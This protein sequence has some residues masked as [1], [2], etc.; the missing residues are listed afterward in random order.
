MKIFVHTINSI[1]DLLIRLLPLNRKSRNRYAYAFLV[2]SRDISDVHRKYGFMKYLPDPVLHFFTRYHWPV[3]VSNI[4]GLRSRRSGESIAGFVIGIPMTARQMME[5]RSVAL[6]RI[7]QASVLARKKG[8]KIIGLG[9]LT[10]SLSKGG[11]DL[12]EKVEINITTGHAYTAY[13]VTNTL[14]KIAQLMDYEK[15]QITV[16][17]VGA[18]GSVGSTSAQILAREGYKKL[19]LVD[20]EKRAHYFDELTRKILEINPTVSI[21]STHRIGEIK[22][23]DIIITATNAPEAVIK[24]DDLKSG[25]IVIDDAQPSDVSPEVLDRDDVLVLDAGVVYTHGINSN[26]NFGLKGRNDNFC[27]LAE[28]LILASEEW[29]DHFV[30][31]RASLELVDKIVALGKNHKFT[32]AHFQ[33]TRQSILPD[34]LLKIKSIIKENR[35]NV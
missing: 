19:I 35:K 2:H 24:S 10:S 17:I 11:L 14:L 3:T 33:N 23:A 18:A 13:T 9:A 16:A 26:F 6:K 7:I 29:N 31:N 28:V 32:I 12:L 21:F 15:T 1:K 22:N 34:K 20:V 5:N 4:T 27:C 30:I 25:A 8:A